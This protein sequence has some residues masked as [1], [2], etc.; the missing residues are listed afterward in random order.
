MLIGTIALLFIV[1]SLYITFQWL[2]EKIKPLKKHK[3][4]DLNIK[5]DIEEVIKEK[6][7]E[8]GEA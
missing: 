1:T 3:T 5:H 2:D 7:A 8:K 6:K 4:Q